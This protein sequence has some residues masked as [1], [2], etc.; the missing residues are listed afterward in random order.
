M[1]EF[2]PDYE[3]TR[4]RIEAFWNFDVLDRPV[5]TFYTAR[6]LKNQIP[7]PVSHHANPADRWM[8][9]RFQAELAYANLYNQEFLGDTLP[10][11]FPNLGPEILSVLYGCPVH[12]GDFG[13]SWTD[14]I[15][16]DWSDVDK[17]QLDWD[18]PF[19][20]KLHEMTDALL[21]IGKD[22]F[23][24]GMTDWHPGADCIAAF[25]DPQ[26]LAIDMLT[27]REKVVRLLERISKDYYRIYDL[28]FHKLRAAGMPI[29]SWTPL[30]SE[31]RFYIPSNDFSIMVSKKMYD[32]VFLP[33]IA[34][35]CKFL[36]RSIYHLDGP[37]AL[38]H[39]DSILSIPELN[40]LQ[41]VF[42]AGNE[43][44]HKWIRVYQK[45]QAARKG[46]QVMCQVS[47]LPMVMDTLSPRGLFIQIEGVQNR[48]MGLDI[49]KTLERWTSTKI[50]RS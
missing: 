21:E 18:S 9:A 42:G 5:T 7:L 31:G 26:N 46:I 8:D 19:L 44:F 41:W 12:F 38:R 32:E 40:A 48:E 23:I 45:A 43:G 17:I 27:D 10:I 3:S 1:F 35:E 34:A 28:F 11:A 39:L 4:K 50:A 2:K 20:Q 24:V 33:G 37:G 30:V 15:L 14:P 6:P 49:L 25:R 22:K 47:E 29:T 16:H 13:T 36:D